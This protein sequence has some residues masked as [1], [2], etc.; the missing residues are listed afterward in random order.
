MEIIVHRKNNLGSLELTPK[1]YG[2][3]IDIRT[4][5]GELIIMHDPFCNGIKLNDWL[6][7]F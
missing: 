2:I 6:K 5:S 7:S 3:E 4:Y 1:K